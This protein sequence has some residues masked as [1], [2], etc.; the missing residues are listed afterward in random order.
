MIY[1]GEMNDANDY[2]LSFLYFL[3]LFCI[4][5]HPETLQCFH[6]SGVM[7]PRRHPTLKKTKSHTIMLETAV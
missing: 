6:Y 5:N 3:Y 1:I 4:V 2:F 7:L